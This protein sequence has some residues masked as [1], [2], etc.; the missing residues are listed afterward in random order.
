MVAAFEA[1]HNIIIIIIFI[2]LFLK[3]IL[4]DTAGC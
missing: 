1:G 2:S 3:Q 4:Q